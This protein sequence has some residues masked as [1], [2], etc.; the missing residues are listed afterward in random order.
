MRIKQQWVPYWDW[1]D[2][3]NGMW[4]K[5][6]KEQESEFL[7]KCITFTSNWIEYG[8]WMQLVV[9]KW[10]NTML[11]SLSSPSINKRAFIGHC[12]CSLAFNCPEYITRMAWKHLTDQQRADAD[13]IAE[14]VYHDWK[15]KQ[16]H[17][18]MEAAML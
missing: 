13:D 1:E 17:R 11:N 7:E 6:D 2:W 12:A 18:Q 9:E 16:L 4:K 3:H 8:K 15:N 5:V 10:P 14:I